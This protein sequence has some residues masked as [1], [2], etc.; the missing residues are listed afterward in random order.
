MTF[1]AELGMAPHAFAF[2]LAQIDALTTV[3]NLRAMRWVI[4]EL[5]TAGYIE[6]EF[7]YCP[8][9]SITLTAEGRAV[10][11]NEKESVI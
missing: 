2:W 11:K 5:E 1:I 7:P 4:A 6:I 3:E 10:I 8:T 9:A